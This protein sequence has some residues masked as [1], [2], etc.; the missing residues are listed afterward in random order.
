MHSF[1]NAMV[2]SDHMRAAG[3]LFDAETQQWQKESQSK[4]LGNEDKIDFV[5]EKIHESDGIISMEGLM[6]SQE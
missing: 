1:F 5:V 3:W 2:S 4:I 6:C